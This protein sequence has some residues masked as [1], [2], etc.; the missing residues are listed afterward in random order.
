MFNAQQ[1]VARLADRQDRWSL[2]KDFVA[3]WH[4]PLQEG[5]GYAA[6]E[7]DAAEQRLGLKLPA[8]LREWYQLAGKRTD[9]F[10][11]DPYGFSDPHELSIEEDDHEVLWLFAENA[12][13]CLMGYSEQDLSQDDPPVYVEG[14]SIAEGLWLANETFSEFILQVIVHQTTCFAEFGGN[15]MGKK[16]TADIVTQNFNLL[17]CRVGVGLA[18][19]HVFM[20]GMMC[21]LS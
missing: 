4:T 10:D 1:F 11:I 5:D 2:L 19:L 17:V 18:T 9:L 15:A 13:G 14:I 21:W 8:A 12:S 16:N 7:L 20:V 6:E 3:E